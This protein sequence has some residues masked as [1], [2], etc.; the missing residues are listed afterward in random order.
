MIHLKNCMKGSKINQVSQISI[1]NIM[2][3]SRQISQQGGVQK[4]ENLLSSKISQVREGEGVSE[5]GNSY[6]VIPCD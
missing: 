4:I 5:L 2:V 3:K 6:Q 1:G